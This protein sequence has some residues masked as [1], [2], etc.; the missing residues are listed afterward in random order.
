DGDLDII[1][2]EFL[3]RLSYF[4]NVG[5]RTEP[6]YAEQRFIQHNGD[7]LHLDLQMLQ[8]VVFDWNRDG[9]PDIFVGKEDGR[10][11]LL[12]GTGKFNEGVPTFTPP[13]YLRQEAD[14]IK[15]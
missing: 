9:N 3:D 4:E 1:A 14:T 5:S 2:G 11:V 15:V 12:L 6:T 7:T 8:V 13:R 10:V